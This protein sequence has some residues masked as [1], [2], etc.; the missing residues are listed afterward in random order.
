MSLQLPG[1]SDSAAN[2]PPY[3]PP[4]NTRV[5][6]SILSDIG[7]SEFLQ[8]FIDDEQDDNCLHSYKNPERISKRY[9]LPSNLA[10]IFVERSR[11]R[12]V[13]ASDLSSISSAL[14]SV[15]PVPSAATA[16]SP[17]DDASLLLK[18]NLKII[19]ELGKGGFGKV[20]RCKDAAQRREVA[21]K[22]VNDPKNAKESMREGQ[23]LLRAL[24]KNIVR[25][26][27]VHDLNPILGNGTCALEMEV[28][29]GGDLLQH[30]EAAR[31]RPE[32]RLPP[33]AVLRLSRQLLETLVYLHDEMK[34]LHGDIKPQNMLMQCS[35][36]PAD[37]SAVDYSSAEIKLADFGLAKVMD[38]RDSTASFMLSNAATQE[39]GI[40]GTMWYVSPEALQS[41]GV[42]E[43]SY[44]DDLWSACLVIFEMDT[45]L[46]LQQ[47]MT[48][49][50]AVKLEMLL[51]KVSPE[52]MPLL[53]SV[54][55]VSDAASRC[56]SAAEL[57]R[58]LDASIDPLYIWQRHDNTANK[59]VSVH[60]ASSFVLEQA[61]SEND[62][63][64][65]L[66]LQPPLDLNFDIKAL[67]SSST[68]LGYQTGRSSGVKCAIRRLL[69]SS[70]LT[71]SADIPTWQELVEGKEWLQCSPALCAKL[72]IS[73]NNP[74]V[75]I[76]ATKYRRVV[77]QPGSI[78]SVQ[79][80]FTMKSEPY[81]E[82]APAAERA[83]LNMRVHD[84]L[85]EWDITDM[86]QV[87]NSALASQYAAY[88]HRVAAR[89][90]GDPNERMMFHFAQPAVMTKIWQEGEG[91]DPRLSNW[92]EVG[93]GAYFSKHV[94]YGYAYNYSLWPSPPSYAVKPEPPIG[95]SMQVFATLVCLGNTADMGP[96]CETCPSPAWDAWKKE[97][98]YQKSIENPNPKPTRPPAMT[99]PA[100]AAEKQH[101]LDLMQVKDAPRCDSVMS[102]EG[103]LGTHPASTNKD[104][105]GRRIC[106][107]M[108]PRLRARA[109]EWAEQYVLFVP[110]AS[111]PMF[112]A[113]LTKTRDSPMGPQQLIDAGCDANRIKA[114]G[115]AARDIKTLGKTAQEMRQAGWS[116][117]DL[118]DAGFDAGSLLTGGCSVSELKR[119]GFTAQQMKTGGCNVQQLK[120]EGYTAKELKCGGFS[121]AALDAASFLVEELKSAGFDDAE[122]HQASQCDCARLTH[123]QHV[124]VYFS[125][126]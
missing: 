72:Q 86:V 20:Y 101:I 61:F 124:I 58:K 119:E 102:T 32:Q 77:L 63:H 125:V 50:G 15:S 51:T 84:S 67:L 33:D 46:P 80:P 43:R 57:L 121:L 12:A 78:G 42:Y 2:V 59:Y 10:S 99:L 29:E 19:C 37:D 14:P 40:K 118:K 27:R 87:V 21:V 17:M 83:I 98:E 55:L 94:M 113:T 71:S 126:P 89:C 68:A 90:N 52:L 39:G 11:A 70:A 81:C 49:P 54:L 107:S 9:S 18:L 47:M 112:I 115:F 103:D 7:A 85:P 30:L 120:D 16:T 106:D 56:N 100:D 35:P 79:L 36:V 76:D 122:I 31:R 24:H 66:P 60:P 13:A 74:N 62:P 8:N 23:K 26:H 97:F 88:R 91:H 73:S 109:K 96:G 25:V 116:I 69:K 65:M 5:L 108:H 6:A 41:R 4:P 44:A 28:V 38:Q 110:A 93:K 104:A 123:R 92:A 22:L 95:M 1:A 114:L 105:S 117:L 3:S 45:C 34:W 82:P 111:Y 75:V 53:C 64:S 48:S